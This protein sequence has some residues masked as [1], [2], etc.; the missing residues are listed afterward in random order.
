MADLFVR[1]ASADSAGGV[2]TITISI[3]GTGCDALAVCIAHNQTDDVISTVTYAGA[4]CTALDTSNNGTTLQM[5]VYQKIAPATGVNNVVV[6]FTAGL[7]HSSAAGAHMFNGTNQTT[8][9]AGVQKASGSST[10]AAVT[11]TAIGASNSG[12]DG[13]ASTPSTS[14]NTPTQ[15]QSF[16]DNNPT[17]C[18]GGSHAA[19][20]ASRT[21]QWT[22][23]GTAPWASIAFEVQAAGAAAANI[24]QAVRP[25]RWATVR[26]LPQRW[27][28]NSLNA[29]S[30][31]AA[32]GAFVLT[33]IAAALQ[34]NDDLVAATGTFTETGRPANLLHGYV[35]SAATGVFVETGNAAGSVRTYNLTAAK[36]TF[37]ETGN[38]INL[39]VG[40]VVSAALGTFVETG[41]ASAFERGY[42]VPA[43][44]GPFVLTGNAANLIYSGAV[45]GSPTSMAQNPFLA[46]PPRGMNRR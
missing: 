34:H 25:A 6:T 38:V 43:S 16:V 27:P 4:A 41:V 24:Q 1:G 42:V 21:F 45:A 18:V 19:G 37:A 3:D 40:R 2:S 8:P 44:V 15:T 17:D 36:G 11:L 7:N 12:F 39:L 13:V 14:I 20:N 32:T 9:F 23:T 22:I 10:T 35:V 46:S 31:P 30:L 5:A 29:Y 26:R 33:G 28:D